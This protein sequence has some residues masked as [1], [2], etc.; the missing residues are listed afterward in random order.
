MPAITM[1]TSGYRSLTRLAIAI[2]LALVVERSIPLSPSFAPSAKTNTSIGFLNIQSI[3]L[4]PPAVV[5]PLTPEGMTS[6]FKFCSLSKDWR[7]FG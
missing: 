3:R 4:R 1:W 2:K 5:S 6:H 7:T